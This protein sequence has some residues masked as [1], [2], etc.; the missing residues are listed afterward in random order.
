MP[1]APVVPLPVLVQ[2]VDLHSPPCVRHGGC[3]PGAAA[4]A[5]SLASPGPHPR[6]PVAVAA[7]A[8]AAPE[9]PDF[10]MAPEAWPREGV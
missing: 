9:R 1:G 10:T 8:A 3:W 2:G 6:R 7:A 5:S 4:A